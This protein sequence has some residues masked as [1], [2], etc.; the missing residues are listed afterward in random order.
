MLQAELEPEVFGGENGE[1]TDREKRL[2]L[3]KKVQIGN[4]IKN[5]LLNLVFGVSREIEGGNCFG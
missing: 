1:R 3:E 2:L 4:S 5:T